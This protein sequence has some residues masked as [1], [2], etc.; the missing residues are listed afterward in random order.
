MIQHHIGRAAGAEAFHH[1]H[2]H[3]GS[4]RPD[5]P[6]ARSDRGCPANAE[7]AA[8]AR[9]PGRLRPVAGLT[10][11]PPTAR[12]RP[13]S[14]RSTATAPP[15]PRRSPG[16]PAG[17]IPRRRSGCGP[18]RGSRRPRARGG[19]RW[20]TG[21]ARSRG[22]VRTCPQDRPGRTVPHFG[23][24]SFEPFVHGADV[25]PSQV[26]PFTPL[27]GGRGAPP[28]VGVGEKLGRHPGRWAA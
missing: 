13:P 12:A 25:R 9:C 5:L 21:G 4:G 24:S 10:P 18:G 28:P 16:P 15:P 27:G 7:D 22:S 17:G 11:P 2:H 6:L 3:L 23:P 14:T 1:P 8:V 20:G 26:T 19:R